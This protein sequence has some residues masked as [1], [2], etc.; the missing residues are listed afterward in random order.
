LSEPLREHP[1]RCPRPDDAH[2]D[3]LIAVLAAAEVRI[4]VP[5][6]VVAVVADRPLRV[7]PG[8]GFQL[9]VHRSAHQKAASSFKSGV[10]VAVRWP[11]LPT[12]R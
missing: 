7:L 6:V 12:G 11:W 3:D 10:S 1:A 2:V 8:L 9:V 5:R 4:T